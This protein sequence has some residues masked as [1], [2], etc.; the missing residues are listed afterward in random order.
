MGIFDWFWPKF[1]SLGRG[2]WKKIS[3]N[4]KCL[5]S[6][7]SSPPPPLGLNIDRCISTHI[8]CVCVINIIIEYSS[9]AHIRLISIYTY[10][11]WVR[12]S[13]QKADHIAI[14]FDQRRNC[15]SPGTPWQTLSF[16]QGGVSL[17]PGW[18]PP[19]SS[20][21]GAVL[22]RFIGRNIAKNQIDGWGHL[23]AI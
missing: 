14:Y 3:Q 20:H 21:V 5:T 1:S 8:T 19:I 13:N 2:N 4:V 9:Y 11:A 18:Q 23:P 12:P 10:S 15:G 7:P 22:Q 17:K 6:A 16:H